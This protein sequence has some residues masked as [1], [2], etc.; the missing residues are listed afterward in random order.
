MNVQFKSL[1]SKYLTLSTCC[2]TL[3]L[4]GQAQ[5]ATVV[6]EPTRC[7]IPPTGLVAWLPGDENAKDIIGDN[8]GVFNGTYEAN[9]KVSKAFQFSGDGTDFVVVPQNAS[10]EPQNVTVDAWVKADGNLGNFKYIL[11][12]GANGCNGAASYALYTGGAN[13]LS[14]YV[15]D[16]TNFAVSPAIPGHLIWDNQWHF[17]AGTYD[18]TSVRMYLDGSPIGTNPTNLVINY[19]LPIRSLSIGQY[20]GCDAQN[21]GFKGAI[22]EVEVFSRAL[23][24]N[25]LA[26]IYNAGK[27]GKCNMEVSVKKFCHNRC[28]NMK[29]RGLIPVRI[30]GSAT[31]DVKN[32][33]KKSLVFNGLPVKLDRFNKPQCRVIKHRRDKYADLLCRFVNNRAAWVANTSSV[34]MTGLMLDK[35][36][37]I[38]NVEVCVMPT[39]EDNDEPDADN[40]Q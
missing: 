14:F 1:C 25:E 13:S 7:A 35:T 6:A 3:M 17:V 20:Q 8:D 12:K 5:A 18:G 11:A 21:F 4:C 38:G 27:L 15:Y 34:T 2:L 39:D 28:I 26:A 37:L 23:T 10:L 30:E 24:D 32:I 36:H 40:D 33:D 19:A 29:H 16:G 22:D 9:G 31:L